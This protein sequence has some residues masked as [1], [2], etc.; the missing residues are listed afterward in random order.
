MIVEIDLSELIEAGIVEQISWDSLACKS[1]DD[2]AGKC[3]DKIV[4]N[5][6]GC[7]ATKGVFKH[8]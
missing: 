1:D 8:G 7:K 6:D 3:L 2:L 4:C 5:E